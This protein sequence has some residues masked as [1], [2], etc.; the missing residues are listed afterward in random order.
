MESVVYGVYLVTLFATARALL[1]DPMGE[2]KKVHWPMFIVMC[3][4]AVFSTLDVALGMRHILD[5][6]IFYTG[7]GGADE[8]FADIS[9]WVNVMKTVDTQV[10]AL[11]G[12]AML[13]YRCFIIYSHKWTVIML[14]LIMW[15]ADA[16]FSV[17]IIWISATL[18]QD[19]V[20]STQVLLKPFLY[21]FFCVTIILNLLTTGLIIFRIWG[22]NKHSAP[23][24]SHQPQTRP[25]R[26]PRT[27]LESVMRIILESGMLYQASVIAT[28][29]CALVGS[30]AIYG[31][32]DV[33]VVAVG[34]SF[35]LIIIRVDRANNPST[36]SQASPSIVSA[37]HGGASYPLRFMRSGQETSQRAVEITITREH[38]LHSEADSD[39]LADSNSIKRESKWGEAV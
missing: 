7:P 18:R 19:A 31:V 36:T 25:A 12:D 35:N 2:R 26:R 37:P 15:A 29:I 39:K 32:S 14:P 17:V 13:I 3:S 1:W 10:M 16:A 20:I 30:N 9:Y 4:M 8:E 22:T 5:A 6:F 33:M 23:Y 38:A 34:I 27:R 11:I 28:F 21:S 24:I